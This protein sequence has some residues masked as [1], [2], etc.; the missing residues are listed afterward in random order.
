MKR[1]NTTL[2]RLAVSA[3]MIGVLTQTTFGLFR[4]SI[5]NGS[6]LSIDFEGTGTITHMN[7]NQPTRLNEP[8]TSLL[9]LNIMRASDLRLGIGGFMSFG[10]LRIGQ[11][12]PGP[13]ITF[14]SYSLEQSNPFTFLFVPVAGTPGVFELNPSAAETLQNLI[15]IHGANNLFLSASFVAGFSSTVSLSVFSAVREIDVDL[16]P[17]NDG[18]PINPK[19]KGK[20]TV[21][22]LTT[23][24]FDATTV[25]VDSLRFGATGSEASAEHSAF[26]D[27]DGDGDLDLVLHFRTQQT[28]IECGAEV[29]LLRG[30][31]LTGE[32]IGRWDT[33]LTVGCR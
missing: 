27:V 15:D 30:T 3:L 11:P 6:S 26:D 9:D 20:I 7:P 22:I 12:A 18:N 14:V 29:A 24:T 23:A 4:F 13:D 25:D 31:S 1:W 28:N 2:A 32:L 17:A 10:T 21:A 16:K 19:G 8:P 5:S 33:I